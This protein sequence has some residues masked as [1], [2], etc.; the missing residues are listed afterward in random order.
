MRAILHIGTEKTGTTALQHCLATNRALLEANGF[1][2]SRAAGSVS[3][4][5]LAMH[6]AP[7][8][9]QDLRAAADLETPD[10]LARHERRLRR[11]LAREVAAFPEACFLFSSEHCHSRVVSSEAI[12]RLHDLLSEFFETI[13]VVV[14]LRRQ[15]RLAT[16]FYST[17][18]RGGGRSERII[19]PALPHCYFDYAALIDRWSAR[20]TDRMIVASY[21]RL[22][23]AGGIVEDFAGRLG[24]PPLAGAHETHNGTLSEAAQEVIRRLNA[25]LAKDHAPLAPE[26]LEL[27]IE[28]DSARGARPGRLPPR[29]AARTFAAH[30]AVANARIAAQFCDGQPLFDADFNDYPIDPPPPPAADIDALF[31]QTIARTMQQNTELRDERIALHESVALAARGNAELRAALDHEREALVAEQRHRASIEAE[32]SYYAG[33]VH[34]DSGRI[35][36]A[37]EYLLSGTSLAPDRAALW[38]LLARIQHAAGETSSAIEAIDRAIALAP[39]DGAYH[40]LRRAISQPTVPPDQTSADRP[41]SRWWQRIGRLR[42]A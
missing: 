26:L 20:F 9:T 33:L 42:Q 13:E 30:F 5:A 1:R 25:H 19:P 11:R 2:Y 34:F 24:L 8:S 23:R 17:Y 35:E 41:D 3:H 15:D 7:D 12:T 28:T 21:D 27:V 36:T 31:A 38:Q 39:D 4:P 29:A 16:S 37:R 10:A 6:A 32:L 14:Y 40:E 22:A 18:V